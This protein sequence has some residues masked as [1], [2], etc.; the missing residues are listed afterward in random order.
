V[1]VRGEQQEVGD[2]EDSEEIAGEMDDNAIE[3]HITTSDFSG[4]V[5]TF[6][7]YAEIEDSMDNMGMID[8]QA[9][10]T[11]QAGNEY[12]FQ[13]VASVVDGVPQRVGNLRKGVLLGA[14][15]KWYRNDHAVDVGLEVTG[16]RGNVHTQTGKAFSAV[17]PANQFYKDG[18][19]CF[20]PAHIMSRNMLENY[21][22]CK[23]EEIDNDIKPEAGEAWS[24]VKASSVIIDLLK[25]NKEYFGIEMRMPSSRDGLIKVN[26]KVIEVCRK[27]LEKQQDIPFIDFNKFSI[28][29]HRIDGEPWGSPKNVINDISGHDECDKA[30]FETTRLHDVKKICGVLQVTAALL[31]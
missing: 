27:Y 2:Q 16:I 26:N 17:A 3:S 7:V 21:S 4:G 13:R 12:I 29:A 23:I 10:W 30:H 31:Q 1:Y 19:E 18:E 22:L 24:Y 6:D 25:A 11:P 15:W 9:E 8:G 28:K 20:Q 14:K 5:Y